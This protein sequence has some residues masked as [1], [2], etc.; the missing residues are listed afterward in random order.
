LQRSLLQRSLLLKNLLLRKPLLTSNV[1]CSFDVTRVPATLLTVWR[2][3][4]RPDSRNVCWVF[5]AS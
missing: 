1:L 2:A 3:G 5:W 4:L